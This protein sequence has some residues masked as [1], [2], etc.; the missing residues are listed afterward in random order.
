MAK[1]IL[2]TVTVIKGNLNKEQK[3]Q[4]EA[5]GL[6]EVSGFTYG[7]ECYSGT[8]C[9][10]KALEYVGELVEAN[11]RNPDL[12]LEVTSD[13]PCGCAYL[14]QHTHLP[15]FSVGGWEYVTMFLDEIV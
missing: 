3:A 8:L 9:G 2:T 10:R 5:I 1:A 4:L 6:P 11:K 12:V 15:C 14:F 13:D 7:E